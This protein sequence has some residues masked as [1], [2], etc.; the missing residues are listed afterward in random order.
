M[1]PTPRTLSLLVQ[2]EQEALR[3]PGWERSQS[4]PQLLLQ[5][6]ELQ[7]LLLQQLLSLKVH[8]LLVLLL[9]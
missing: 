5:S 6:L 1:R 8:L 9:Q 3:W 2:P 7:L 4:P